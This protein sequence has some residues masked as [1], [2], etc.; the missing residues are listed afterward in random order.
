MSSGLLRADGVALAIFL[1]SKH[2]N[3]KALVG[4]ATGLLAGVTKPITYALIMRFRRTILIVVIA[5]AIGAALNATFQAKLTTFAFHSLLS[6]SV[7]MLILQY[8]IKTGTGFCLLLL[9]TLMFG[10]ENKSVSVKNQRK[11][12]A[13]TTTIA[14]N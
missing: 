14:T 12:M 11:P 5:A 1:R 9:L 3:V 7:F 2:V 4:P 13:T 6:I 10:F 8:A